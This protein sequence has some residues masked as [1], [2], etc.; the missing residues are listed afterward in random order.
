MGKGK[1]ERGGRGGE[2][3]GP[4]RETG[5]MAGEGDPTRERTTLPPAPS[6][7]LELAERIRLIEPRPAPAPRP[8]LA[9]K[10]TNCSQACM[11]RSTTPRRLLMQQGLESRRKN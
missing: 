1:G 3:G 11:V 4:A 7:V 2:M 6:L 5:G 10:I 9:V 8:S